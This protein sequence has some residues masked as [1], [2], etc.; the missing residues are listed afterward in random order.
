MTPG[1]PHAVDDGSR[2]MKRP[3]LDLVLAGYDGKPDC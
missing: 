3:P 1:Q 2:Q